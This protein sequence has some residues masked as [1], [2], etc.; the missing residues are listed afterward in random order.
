[1]AYSTLVDSMLNKPTLNKSSLANETMAHASIANFVVFVGELNKDPHQD[2][3]GA[4][5]KSYNLP[6][7]QDELISMS[8]KVNKNLIVVLLSG[9]AIAMTWKHEM[10]AMVQAWYLSSEAGNAIANILSGKA[11]PSGKL[12]FMFPILL[13]DNGLNSLGI[14]TYPDNETGVFH[15][16][17]ILVGYRWFEQKK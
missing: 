5:T 9:N 2:S 13:E 6:Y 1:M 15:N 8:V 7:G 4:D 10:R 12:P 17:D 3:E 11:I 14:E 16:E